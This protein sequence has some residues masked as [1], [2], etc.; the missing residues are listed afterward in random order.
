[1]NILKINIK[2]ESGFAII[3]ALLI[4]A[5]MTAIGIAVLVTSTTDIMI[6]RNTKEAKTA[7][8]LADTG[9]EEAIA[10]VDLNEVDNRFMGETIDE[11]LT[12]EAGTTTTFVSTAF[13]S[14]GTGDLN[15]SGLGGRYDVTIIY[16]IESSATWCDGVV[17]GSGGDGCTGEIVLYCTD[18]GFSGLGVPSNCTN[19]LPVYQIDSTGTTTAT[20][21][22][23]SVRA[24]I[25]G[26]SL[27][28]VPPGD[29]ILFTE[30][31]IYIQTGKTVNGNVASTDAQVNNCTG[32]CTD[33]S[34][35]T[36]ITGWNEGDMENYLGIAINNIGTYADL[37]YSQSGTS[38]A[39]Y[40]T[41]DWGTPCDGTDTGNVETTHIC[42]NESKLIYI[43]N[44]GAGTAKLNSN[45]VGR[46]IVVVTGDL[47]LSGGLV[48]EG[49]LYVMGNL[50]VVGNA[51][52][53][54]TIMVQGDN[55]TSTNNDSDINGNLEIYGSIPVALSVAQGIGIP[56]FLRWSR[57]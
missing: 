51:I 46:G 35:N 23:A 5:A 31:G 24:H 13:S 53:Y 34:S 44:A 3:L 40:D 56:K 8:F 52:I 43:D 48:W 22:V 14:D 4:M 15:L 57:Q 2:D 32:D 28:V 39:N 6:A 50:E 1:M 10:R 55:T 29:S 38:V 25:A 37:Q 54:G 19:A 16:A 45:S 36:E 33:I 11:K 49:V 17:M 30:G 7:F 18:Y 12:R 20:G 27:N 42:G 41:S 47:K 9:I 21:T 26:S